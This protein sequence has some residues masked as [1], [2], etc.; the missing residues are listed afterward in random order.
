[1]N[2]NI[3]T[4]VVRRNKTLFKSEYCNKDKLIAHPFRIPEFCFVAD[5]NR[6]GFLFTKTKI[7]E[8]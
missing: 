7:S 5:S 1:M 4:F 3:L 2:K 6:V 8:N